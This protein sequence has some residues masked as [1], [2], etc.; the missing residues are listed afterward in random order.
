MTATATRTVTRSHRLRDLYDQRTLFAARVTLS[1]LVMAEAEETV[2]KVGFGWVPKPD[3]PST[4]ESLLDAYARS[5]ETGEP[6]PVYSGDNESVTFIGPEV[7][8]AL[9]YW[10]DCHH[11]ALGLSFVPV[12]ELELALWHLSTVEAAGLGPDTLPYQLL[13]ADLVGAVFT[14]VLARRFPL[15]QRRFTDAAVRDGFHHALLAEVRRTP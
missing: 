8:L 6:L 1:E 11:V 10:H 3:A 4:Y 14:S 13:Q 15:N 7:N 2:R 5:A 9:R 12:D